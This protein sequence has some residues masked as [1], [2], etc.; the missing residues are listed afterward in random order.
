M[1]IR[2]SPIDDPR[3]ATQEDCEVLLAE[4]Q[5]VDA[6]ATL[7]AALPVF[8]SADLAFLPV[9]T[10]DE[11][12]SNQVVVGTLFHIDA[13]KAYNNALAATAAEEHS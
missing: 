1:C 7:E 5:F 3:S 11:D 4:G 13:L 2:D 10:S 8:E 9:V 6:A 12:G